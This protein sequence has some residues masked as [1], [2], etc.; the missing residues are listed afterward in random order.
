MRKVVTECSGTRKE[1]QVL[2]SAAGDHEVKIARNASLPIT[3]ASGTDVIKEYPDGRKQIIGHVAKDIVVK[4][5]H[6]KIG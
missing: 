3:Y 6:I 2:F 1:R 5:R 4:D